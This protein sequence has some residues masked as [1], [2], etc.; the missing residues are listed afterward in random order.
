MTTYQ[1]KEAHENGIFLFPEILDEEFDVRISERIQEFINSQEEINLEKA[2]VAYHEHDGWQEHPVGVKYHQEYF[3]EQADS[4]KID[5]ES[6]H[7]MS[8]LIDVTKVT[9]AYH[10]Q[11]TSD[12]RGEHQLLL[13]A[14]FKKYKI[15]SVHIKKIKRLVFDDGHETLVGSHNKGEIVLYNLDKEKK[16]LQENIIHE[17]GHAVHGDLS[18]NGH[19]E[20]DR[21]WIDAKIAISPY[22]ETKWNQDLKTYDVKMKP[23]SNL[24]NYGFPSEY[25]VT[26]IFEFFAEC[27][28]AFF[29]NREFL[30]KI[31]LRIVTLFDKEF[32]LSK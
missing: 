25:S 24:A 27:Y 32:G 5:T 12:Q 21:I 18:S 8:Y 20:F 3:S 22:I 28:T 10:N 4:S 2:K 29:M 11:F 13:S 14:A 19:N 9:E 1:E 31:N 15:P 30:E 16:Y 7:L 23:G 6:F 26:N 17:L